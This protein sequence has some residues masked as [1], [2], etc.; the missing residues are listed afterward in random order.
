[1]LTFY[2]I[3]QTFVFIAQLEGMNNNNNNTNKNDNNIYYLL[4][5]LCLCMKNVIKCLYCLLD[6]NTYPML[7]DKKIKSSAK[8][9]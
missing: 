5:I 9:Q 8:L 7:H 6:K 2:R 4:I 1:M 3:K